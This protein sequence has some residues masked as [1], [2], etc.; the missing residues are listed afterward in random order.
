MY[1]IKTKEY[2]FRT[3]ITLQRKFFGIWIYRDGWNVRSTSDFLRER[4]T[5]KIIKRLHELKNITDVIN[6]A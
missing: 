4:E 1:R 6:C 2:I 3:S 5:N